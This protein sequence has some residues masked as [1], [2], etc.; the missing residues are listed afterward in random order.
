M[1]AYAILSTVLLAPKEMTRDAGKSG[2]HRKPFKNSSQVVCVA[3]SWDWFAL[4]PHKDVH[5]CLRRLPDEIS[6]FHVPFCWALQF[7]FLL[8]STMQ[9]P[10]ARF[11]CVDVRCALKV[12]LQANRF[13]DSQPVNQWTVQ[14]GGATHAIVIWH[15]HCRLTGCFEWRIFPWRKKQLRDRIWTAN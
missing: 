8:C 7:P 5:S 2:L 9:V 12:C 10:L 13:S 4:G 14:H 6:N 15:A 1:R 11:D 3:N